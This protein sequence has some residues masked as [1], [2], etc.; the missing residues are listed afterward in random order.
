LDPL[1]F[2]TPQTWDRRLVDL[3]S[4]TFQIDVSQ[5]CTDDLPRPVR[6]QESLVL[7]DPAKDIALEEVLQLWILQLDI[8][9]LDLYRTVPLRS[10]HP[11]FITG[12]K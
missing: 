10:L 9:V 5:G 1:Q 4:H 12:R 7:E 6:L 3:L 2:R 8:L 11:G